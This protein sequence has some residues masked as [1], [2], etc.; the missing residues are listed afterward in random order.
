MEKGGMTADSA[1]KIMQNSC[2]LKLKEK[3]GD[4]IPEAIS[5]RYLSELKNI[6]AN[7][8]APKYLLAAKLAEKSSELG[9]LHNVRGCGAGAFISYLL[10]I[11]ETN[12][13]PPHYYCPNC[14]KVEFVGPADFPSGFDLNQPEKG[15]KVCP[16]CGST[17][18]G[19]GHNIPVEFFAGYDGD[20]IP[21]FS[22][23]FASEIQEDMAE[24]YEELCAKDHDSASGVKEKCT[25]DQHERPRKYDILGQSMFGKL[26]QM[27]DMTGISPKSISLD[28][29][30]DLDLSLLFEGD[31]FDVSAYDSAFLRSI[32]EAVHPTNFSELVKV[33]GFLHG[34]DVWTNNAEKLI[35]N[36]CSLQEVAA[37]REDIMLMLIK[38]GVDRKTAF[39]IAEQVGKGRIQRNGFSNEQEEILKEHEVP[40]WL[41]SSMSKVSY[42]FPKSHAIEYVVNYLRLLWYKEH[43]P[44]EFA[45]LSE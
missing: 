6:V 45:Q 7:G 36:G 1:E 41:I 4:D 8:F 27:E 38:Y 11:A 17:M 18:V 2:E 44:D 19:D 14:K 25:S 21:D 3:Y 9:Y 35:G 30:S 39:D 31:I 33:Y 13:L 34:T 16:V 5:E 26:K 28:D 29:V 24:Y 42:L 12:P 23:N 10:G 20:K 32:A 22:F 15:R 43:F 37:F 40:A